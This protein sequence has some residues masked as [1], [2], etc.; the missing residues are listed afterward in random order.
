MRKTVAV[1]ALILVVAAPA[2]AEISAVHLELVYEGFLTEYPDT[3]VFSY[4]LMVEITGE[5]A[6]TAAGGLVL[7]APWAWL[8]GG[9]FFQHPY[10]PGPPGPPPIQPDP[11]LFWLY[12]DLRYD[13]FYTTHLGWP[14]TED[15]GVEPGFAYGPADTETELIAGWFWTPDGNFYPGDFTI[16]RL[17]VIPDGEGWWLEGAVQVCSIESPLEPF[18]FGV[19][20]PGSVVLLALAGAVLLRRR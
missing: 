5:D 13:T 12:P 19:A 4:D 8:D 10:V 17:T 14:N 15:Q 3:Y 11:D 1:V 16:A 18:Y 20:E 2:V 7:G 9:V 6:W